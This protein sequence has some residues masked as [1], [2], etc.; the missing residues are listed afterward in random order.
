MV[1]VKL[2]VSIQEPELRIKHLGVKSF[3]N[4]IVWQ[5]SDSAGFSH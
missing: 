5:K 3:Q 2:I 1:R 4:F